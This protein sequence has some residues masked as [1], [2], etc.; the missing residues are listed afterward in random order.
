MSQF[1]TLRFPCPAHCDATQSF[2][3]YGSGGDGNSVPFCAHVHQVVNFIF[4][5]IYILML[6]TG[7]VGYDNALD[8]IIVSH[9][10]GDGQN[11]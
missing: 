7:F 5:V 9:E 10:G 4:L 6:S 11:L 8:S 3:I 1:L 2:N